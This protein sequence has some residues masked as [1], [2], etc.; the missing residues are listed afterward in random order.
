MNRIAMLGLCLWLCVGGDAIAQQTESVVP[1]QFAFRLARIMLKDG[2]IQTGWLVGTLRDS[3]VIH[4]GSQSVRLSRHDLARV[5]IE[6]KPKR[7]TPELVGALL[8]IYLGD[9]LVLRAERQPDLFVRDRDAPETIV[10][11]SALFALAGGAV[12]YI[13]ATVQGDE[14]TMDFSGNEEDNDAAW[15][16][17][18]GT[19]AEANRQGNFHLSMQASWISGPLPKNLTGGYFSSQTAA[20]WNMLRRL[21]LTYSVTDYAEVGLARMWLGQPSTMSYMANPVWINTNIN[22]DGKGYFVV[23]VVQPLW[24][25]T[26]RNVHWDIG[27]GVGLISFDFSGTSWT[28]TPWLESPMTT[29]A[30]RKDVLGAMAYTE[31]KVFVSGY[32][33]L[34]LTAD[35]VI[36]SES[37]PN[38]TGV[39]FDSSTLGTSS[40]G[41]TFGF[42][43]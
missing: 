19:Q 1:S 2:S 10:L 13:A 27:A 42:H 18:A 40:V 9:A 37:V 29:V 4:A 41:V 20:S 22:F 30:L 3:V 28:Y 23:G 25:L 8:G 17:L 15:A 31:L 5:V 36:T 32:F 38:I 16:R 21:Q 6:T 12:G 11:Y 43:L 24:K 34:G 7:S 35:V 14:T 26:G 33:S 39:T